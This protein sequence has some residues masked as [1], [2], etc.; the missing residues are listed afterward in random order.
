MSVV[1]KAVRAANEAFRFGSPWRTL[2]ASERGKL[3]FR[4]TELVERDAQ[5]LAVSVL[6]YVTQ[7]QSTSIH[8]T[9][10]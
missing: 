5:Y 4:L 1:D 7:L 10:I 8:M 6:V 2:D 9:I 3:L